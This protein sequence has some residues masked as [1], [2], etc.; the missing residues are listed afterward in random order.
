MEVAYGMV[1]VRSTIELRSDVANKRRAVFRVYGNRV[2]HSYPVQYEQISAMVGLCGVQ[3]F[4]KFMLSPLETRKSVIS[5]MSPVNNF[6]KSSAKW[7]N[8]IVYA[9]ALKIGKRE[10][11][12][13]MR[14]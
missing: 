10:M 14:K 13:N 9:I 3:L 4:N 8:D 11:S 2:F 6:I 12:D 1:F 7:E 5:I